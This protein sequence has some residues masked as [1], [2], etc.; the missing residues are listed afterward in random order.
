MNKARRKIDAALK[1]E[2]ALE[3]LR[4][5][6]TVS[7]LSQRYQVHPKQIYAWK[8]QLQEQ[9][10]R[11]FD[12][13]L[14]HEADPRAPRETQPYPRL[15]ELTIEHNAG[16]A[17]AGPI[18]ELDF[19]ESLN[20]HRFAEAAEKEALT[21]AR[22]LLKDYLADGTV[23]TLQLLREY[24]ARFEMVVE[25]TAETAKALRNGAAIVPIHGLTGRL[26]PQAINRNTG[27]NLELF[28]EIGGTRKAIT[29]A[30]AVS[31]IIVSAAHMIAAADLSRK[32]DLVGKKLDL[33]LAYRRI[34]QEARLERIYNSARELL[35]A[36]L[37]PAR[38]ME[39]WRLRGE[40]RELRATWRCE[41]ERHLTQISN[42]GDE[43]WFYRQ[44]T[45]QQGNDE[46][47][48]EKIFE[49]E[50]QLVMV[51]YSLRL[52]RVLAG[53]SDSWS[54]SDATL[55]GELTA[56]K[57]VAVLLRKKAQFI[58]EERRGSVQSM[59]NGMEQIVTHYRGLLQSRPPSLTHN[60]NRP[61]QPNAN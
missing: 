37:D 29:A 19:I 26:L 1:A 38:R 8:K 33:L 10:I 52:D 46:Q 6:T 5:Q 39:L 21:Y 22:S 30:A 23:L 45:T 43:H 14:G 25:A 58:S 61:D 17:C 54:Q 40:L 2:I 27:R 4:E 11:V 53:A 41:L 24:G 18:R 16:L 51:E 57:D 50:R 47:I 3:A 48:T 44:F 35:A 56:I 15:A 12:A 31:T 13:K 60:E 28:K 49:G 9:A 32:L 20:P 55:A 7:D 34:D 59:V 42:P 36:P